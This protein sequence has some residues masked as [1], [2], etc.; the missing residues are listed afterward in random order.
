MTNS[1][2][3]PNP[4]DTIS[5][6]TRFVATGAFSGY[7]PIASG[8]AG[9]A[10]GAIVYL[11]PGTESLIKLALLIVIFFIIGVFTSTKMELVHGK[12]PSIVVIDEV[13][14]MWISLI[15]LPKTI[16]V[17]ILSFL[18]FR[19][20][21]IFKPPPARNFDSMHGGFGIMMDDVVAALY[22]NISVWLIGL[23]FPSIFTVG[24]L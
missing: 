20:Y 7:S 11:I 12:D 8:T 9:S 2:G 15:L 24:K 22:A 16:W 13:V 17:I 18:L 3:P 14:G 6:I 5:W 23:I 19:I 10:V 21:D 4:P 1:S